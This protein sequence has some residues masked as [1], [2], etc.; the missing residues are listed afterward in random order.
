MPAERP[1]PGRRALGLHPQAELLEIRRQRAHVVVAE[2]LVDQPPHL[3]PD[4]RR[5]GDLLGSLRDQ[6]VDRS[7]PLGE[8]AARSRRRRAGSPSPNS[9]RPNGRSFAS[10]IGRRAGARSH[11]ADAL[12]AA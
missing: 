1:L 12:D 10:S 9:T 11:L 3:R 6:R 7:E 4:A 5:L 8:V 2:L